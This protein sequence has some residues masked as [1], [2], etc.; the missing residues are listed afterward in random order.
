M[1]TKKWS[2]LAVVFIIAGFAGMAFQ[3]FKFGDDLPFTEQ[4]WSFGSGELKNLT[5]DT[6]YNIDLNFIDSPDGTNYV[7]VEGNM[8]QEV[9]DKLKNTKL[10]NQSLNVD[11]REDKNNW[12]F[13]NISFQST[14]QQITVA[15]ADKGELLD[16][17]IVR[18]GSSNVESA[19][20]R[21]KEINIDITSGNIKL[22]DAQSNQIQ[23]KGTSG[24]ITLDNI[25]GD[26]TVKLFSGNIKLNQIEGT[27]S[28]KGTSG[29]I[30]ADQIQ[31]DTEASVTSG[32]IKFNAFTG[33][34]KFK[35]T[36]GNITLSGQRSDS[37]DIEV[38][39]G[40]ARLSEDPEF[41]GFYDLQTGSG[42]IKA[43][44]SPQQ[45]KDVIKVRAGSGNI[46]IQN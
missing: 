33:N 8:D 12:S 44:D 4:K 40:N 35:A 26:T 46:R 22:A 43:P 25:Q 29:N 14:K 41:K 42:N 9:I 30:T 45:S 2:F 6:D 1:S 7:Q 37:L 3:G 34:G 24:N 18:G 19:G 38:T 31:G 23:V 15:L 16:S 10:S 17:F 28:A 13:I 39:S 27:L 20:V 5:I 21:S 36:S 11:L 32:N